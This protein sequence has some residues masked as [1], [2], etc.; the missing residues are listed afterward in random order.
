M[1]FDDSGQAGYG[2]VHAG[3]NHGEIL[4]F[5]IVAAALPHIDLGSESV[6]IAK[7]IQAI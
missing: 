6:D 7:P 3:W 2:C 5:L 4:Q 1:V